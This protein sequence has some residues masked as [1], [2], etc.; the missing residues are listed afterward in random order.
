MF[1]FFSLRLLETAEL[2][3]QLNR[4]P[5]LIWFIPI[6]HSEFHY[7]IPLSAV[8][9]SQLLRI[10]LPS[11][12]LTIVVLVNGTLLSSRLIIAQDAAKP[13]ATEERAAGSD[14]KLKTLPGSVSFNA[15]IRPIMSNTCFACHGPD[16]EENHSDLRLD[17]FEAATEIGEAI[18]PGDAT[19]SLVYERLMDEDDPMPPEEFLHQLSDYDKALF[20]K[21]IDQGAQYQQHW[22]YAPIERPEPPVAQRKIEQNPNRRSEIDAFIA[23]RLELE[24]LQPTPRADKPTLLR[25]LSLDLT[26]LPPTRAELADFLADDSAAAYQKQVDRLLASPRYGERMATQWLDIVRFSDTVGFHG[27]QNQRIFPYRDYVIDAFNSNKP[28]DA[29]T[30]E[31]LAGDLLE[32]PTDQQRIAT[33]LIRL[34]MMTREGGAQPKEYLAKYAADR[35]R[36]LGTAFLGSTTGCC[37]CHN[38]KYDPYSIKDF[39]SLGAFFD[40]ILQWGVYTNYDY[41][42]NPDLKGFSNDFPFP[43]EI[44]TKSQS[45]LRQIQSLENELLHRLASRVPSGQSSSAKK[46]PALKDWVRQT[47]QIL[48]RH[49]D[50]WLPLKVGKTSSTQQTPIETL[51][52][53]SVLLTG[54]RRKDDSIEIEAVVPL[55]LSVASLRLE[56][57]PDANN[58]G[59]VGR[60][61]G[62][63]F[64]L[65]L[66]AFL[67]SSQ[68]DNPTPLKFHLAQANRLKETSFESGRS[69]TNLIERWRSGPNRWQLPE[70]ETELNHTAVFHLDS[71]RSLTPDDRLTFRIQSA[72]VGRIR[73]SV[74]PVKRMV[75]SLPAI[76]PSL[77]SAIRAVSDEPVPDDSPQQIVAGNYRF[78]TTPYVELTE[79]CRRLQQQIVSLNSGM[80]MSLVARNVSETSI[81]ETRRRRSRIL[82]RGDWQDTSGEAVTPATPEFLPSLPVANTREL[83]RLDLADWLVSDVNPLTARHY[84]NRTWKHFFGA[85]LSNQLDDLGNQ[86][87]WPSHPL[88]L[89]WLAS[90]FRSNWDMKHIAKLIVMSDTYQQQAAVRSD[91]SEIDPANRLL[92]QQSARRLEAEAVRDNALAI[93]GLL[94]DDFIGGP[95]VFPWQPDGHYAN[96]QF[97]N[98]TYTAS[99]TP[100]QYRRGV[101]M[102]W[103]R[104]FLHP[105]LVNF[106]AP[107][108]DECTAARN[109][110]NSPQQALTLLNDPEFSEAAKA[111]AARLLVES[112]DASFNDRLDAA[113]LLALSRTASDGEHIR[114]NTFHQQQLTHYAANPS[115]VDNLISGNGMFTA[116]EEVDPLS[117]AAWTQVC[118]V[119]LNLHETITRY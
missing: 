109:L 13:R 66:E 114:L 87:E 31:Q 50:G 62:G 43:P 112:P 70:N 22:S 38:H 52:D 16:E 20:R 35:V 84:V 54:K 45:A 63:S 51:A 93:S 78:S 37:E 99:R 32:N 83:T 79:D 76:T 46:V 67:V 118:R 68:Q 4:V 44:R 96:I 111:F 102:H 48:Q 94:F 107:S 40:D 95:S 6:H 47:S 81:G 30:R 2:L 90:E 101:Y 85:G 56:V 33:G 27:D 117:L 119:I 12:I 10:P 29:F 36:M 98:R 25:R 23:A 7:C 9:R 26:G 11:A 14:G 108:R 110:S 53:Q 80:V 74:T 82:P 73:L 103:Q 69:T 60:G 18:I 3:L 21:W 15:H 34:N 106:D 61:P 28:F 42:P 115:D 71:P 58:G 75:A 49:D 89:D 116:P 57:L 5:I 92:S 100:L 1:F 8:T 41:T 97:P 55:P 113:F 19:G 77:A 104:T 88:L 105:M 17:S 91:L 39:Y 59:R 24:G 65:K 72:D 86:G 64:D